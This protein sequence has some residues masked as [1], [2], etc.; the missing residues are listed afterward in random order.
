M[1]HES[2]IKKAS[3][4]KNNIYYLANSPLRIRLICSHTWFIVIQHINKQLLG[5]INR[6]QRIIELIYSWTH[7]PASCSSGAKGFLQRDYWRRHWLAVKFKC[8]GLSN[9]NFRSIN[10]TQCQSIMCCD[11]WTTWWQFNLLDQGSILLPVSCR[12]RQNQKKD[13]LQ[14]YSLHHHIPLINTKPFAKYVYYTPTIVCN[15]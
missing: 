12:C 15:K 1:G 2:E 5:K 13:I 14:H 8:K 4:C 11:M 9:H 6:C 3:F 10:K 7:R